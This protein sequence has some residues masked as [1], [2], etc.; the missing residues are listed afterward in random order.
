M[1]RGSASRPA[2]AADPDG[3]P[4]ASA[5]PTAGGCAPSS[6]RL[7]AGNTRRSSADYLVRSGE[8]DNRDRAAP[9]P[10]RRAAIIAMARPLTPCG[11]TPARTKTSWEEPCLSMERVSECSQDRCYV[12][13]LSESMFKRSCEKENGV[14]AP[15][16]RTAEVAHSLDFG[17]VVRSR[18]RSR[19]QGANDHPRRSEAN[20]QE[21]RTRPRMTRTHFDYCRHGRH[22]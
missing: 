15:N 17:K 10:P 3:P 18:S 2:R 8:D 21:L 11:H 1:H 16:P 12:Y 4:L 6:A 13:V 9:A 14:G 19:A 20:R 7:R 22:V 5:R